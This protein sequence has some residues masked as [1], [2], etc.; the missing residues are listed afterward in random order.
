MLAKY[1]GE[2]SLFGVTIHAEQ[3]K[4]D[5]PSIASGMLP[6]LKQVHDRLPARE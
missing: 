6:F 4:A 1:I 3:L 2:Q 5:A